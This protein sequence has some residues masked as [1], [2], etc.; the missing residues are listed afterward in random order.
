MLCRAIRLS[1]GGSLKME[2]VAVSPTPPQGKD[3][4][5]IGNHLD[6]IVLAMSSPEGEPLV[7]LVRASL[8][9]YVGRTP[10]LIISDRPFAARPEEHIA[11]LSFPF[12]PDELHDKV[13]GILQ[14]A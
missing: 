3:L 1:L 2:V 9:E 4:S 12:R 13:R 8:A 10:L 5:A 7:A 14:P 6:L 11:H